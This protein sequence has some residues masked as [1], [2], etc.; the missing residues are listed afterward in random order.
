MCL[1]P[2]VTLL[3]YRPA[4]GFGFISFDDGLYVYENPHVLAGI[5]PAG[6]TWALK[7]FVAANW[8]PLTLISLM[9]DCQLYGPGAAGF[10]L[11]NLLLHSAN[12]VLLFAVLRH[13]TRQFWPAFLVAALFAWHPLNVESVAWVSERK[14]V[15]STLFLLLSL[16]SYAHYTRQRTVWTYLLT[17]G[18]FTLGLMAKPMLVSL[19]FLML[20]LDYWPLERITL[21]PES[22]S[23]RNTVQAGMKLAVEKLPFLLLSVAV[24]VLTMA[25]QTTGHSVMSLNEC[26]LGLRLFNVPAACGA[27]V[28]NTIWPAHLCIFYPMPKEWPVKGA[29]ASLLL[30]GAGFLLAFRWRTRFRWLLVGWGWFVLAL[31]PVIG[32]VQTGLQARADRH[33]YVPDLGLFIILAWSMH[34]WAVKKPL[35]RPWIAG[36]C[37]AG[38]IG[39]IGAT[40]AQ[41]SYWHDSISAF[42]RAISVTPDNYYMQNNLG[43]AYDEAGR[44]GEALARFKAAVHS[45]PA[46]VESQYHLGQELMRA[47]QFGEAAAHFSAALR[48]MP[49]NILLLNNFGVAQA[50]CGRSDS[51][52][53]QFLAAIRLHPEYSKAYFNLALLEKDNGENGAATTN[54]LTAIRLDPDWAEALNAAAAFQL[55][56]PEARWRDP[57]G[58]L[59]LA[60]RAN[61]VSGGHVAGF[62]ATQGECEAANGNFSNAVVVIRMAEQIARQQNLTTLA[63]QCD[64]DLKSC[65]AGK[66]PTHF[67]TAVTIGTP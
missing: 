19:P 63:D 28:L 39:F 13:M 46:D 22:G 54:F 57:V 45:N 33:A 62:L 41:L 17:L 56:C 5:S 14:N 47:G 21:P 15:L 23:W 16:W 3:L 4:T 59:E 67:V 37:A 10:H 38:L 31:L 65:E 40:R 61:K 35:L 36:A 34:Y 7:A 44:T 11:T 53:T 66:M 58:A 29:F 52:R 55:G 12:A 32:I 25:A 30:I 27:Y 43:V 6:V 24:C 18:W 49:G 1:L 26:P 2:V 9:L 60:K 50:R 42:S 64:D 51:A 48:L 20:L 8:H